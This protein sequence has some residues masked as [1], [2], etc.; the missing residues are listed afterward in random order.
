MKISVITVNLNDINGLRR[1]VSS[2][3]EQTYKDYEYIVIDG[4]STDGSREYIASIDKIS[5]WISEPD[6]GIY[7]AMNKGL[8]IAQGEYCIFMN[9]GDFFYNKD[10]LEEIAPFL[11]GKD[12]YAGQPILVKNGKL[13]CIKLPKIITLDFLFVWSLYHQCT[14]TK[15]SLLKKRPYNENYR[16]VSDWEKFFKEWLLH[17]ASY[18]VLDKIIAYHHLDG[19]SSTNK[20]LNEKERKDVIHKLIPESYYRKLERRFEV[21]TNLG[22]FENKIYNSLHLSPIKRDLKIIRN[23][24]KLLIR[25]IIN[26]IASPKRNYPT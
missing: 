17:N 22:K 5:Y 10:V 7:N 11:Q 2:I 26:M 16:I 21:S 3:I 8:S 14:F 6:T 4:G 18:E 19:I 23:S 12:F 13:N 25:D 20:A 15:T 9:S 1:T 24:L